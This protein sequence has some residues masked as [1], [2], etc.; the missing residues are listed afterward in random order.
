M[1]EV[2]NQ[3]VDNKGPNGPTLG[4]LPKPENQKNGK[5][6]IA[7]W[8]I[9]ILM[10]VFF[11]FYFGTGSVDLE[12]V[13]MSLLPAPIFLSLALYLSVNNR[14]VKIIIAIPIVILVS[15]FAWLIVSHSNS[16]DFYPGAGIFF[17]QL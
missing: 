10:T 15:L 2:G 16:I 11:L 6:L 3:T 4:G 12:P 13:V 14:T 17:N 7:I 9:A 5:S 1:E 8:L